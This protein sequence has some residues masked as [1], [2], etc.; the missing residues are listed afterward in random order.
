MGSRFTTTQPVLEANRKQAKAVVLFVYEG[1]GFLL[2]IQLWYHNRKR[3][4]WLQRWRGCFFLFQAPQFLS[5]FL[6]HRSPRTQEPGDKSKTSHKQFKNSTQYLISDDINSI[7]VSDS[8]HNNHFLVQASS[9]KTI[10]RSRK[11]L[12]C[13]RQHFWE[14]DTSRCICTG[15]IMLRIAGGQ[16]PPK[17]SPPHARLIPAM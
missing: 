7:D 11:D 5:T 17:K 9:S 16:N 14:V 10:Q 1:G 2:R 13:T 6:T 3:R 12:L 8:T 4:G 15:I